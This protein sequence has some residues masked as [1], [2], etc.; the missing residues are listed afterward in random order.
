[1]NTKTKAALRS[2]L[3]QESKA[4]EARLPEAVAEAPVSV[5]AVEA[6][7][8]RWLC[9]KPCP[10]RSKWR[11][12]RRRPV[13][14]EPVA[15]P[16]G[17]RRPSCRRKRRA[18][19]AKETAAPPPPRPVAAVKPQGRP[20]AAKAA[21]KPAAPVAAPAAQAADKK[22]KRRQAVKVEKAVKPRRSRR[23]PRL[24]SQGGK[25]EKPVKLPREK[26]VRDSFSMPKSEH[27]QLKA[28]RETLAKGGRI[29]T[30]SEL[31]RAGIQLL[32]K[33]PAADAKALVEAC[34][35]CRRARAP[36]KRWPAPAGLPVRRRWPLPPLRPTRTRTSPRSPLP[37]NTASAPCRSSR[38]RRASCPAFPQQAPPQHAVQ[39]PGRGGVISTPPARRRHSCGRLP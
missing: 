30:K 31:L 7:P 13:E 12:S 39:Q 18:A 4:L 37:T 14:P 24:P 25:A 17:G 22:A 16:V 32:L 15:A 27:A 36:S 10:R 3:E 9:P 35:W 2:S 6:A 23:S 21:A 1:M 29:C 11:P 5:A 8:L 38:P 28:L 19:A 20:A 34:R 26:V 33:V